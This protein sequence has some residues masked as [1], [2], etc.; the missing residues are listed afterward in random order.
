[1]KPAF[2]YPDVPHVRRHGPMGYL[3]YESFREWLRDEF[4]FRCVACLTR[5]VWQ[6][7]GFHLDHFTP[8]SHDPDLRTEYTNL[9]Y[10]CASCNQIKRQLLLPDP[11][12]HLIAANVE[13]QSDGELLT[14]TV[15]A[16][17]IVNGLRLNRLELC[18]YRRMWSN[19]IAMAFQANPQL[20]QQLMGYP[21]ELPNLALLRP[22]GGNTKPEGIEQ[23]YLCQRERGELPETY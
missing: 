21:V 17:R 5:E 16:R 12:R 10:L 11:T 4:A 2:V 8:T 19:V 18:R 23:S 9:L 6:V 20:H 3:D 1:M 13:L 22:P 7:G 15:S 14:R